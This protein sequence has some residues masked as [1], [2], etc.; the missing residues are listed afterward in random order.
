[1][2]NTSFNTLAEIIDWASKQERCH[3]AQWFYRGHANKK[4]YY[5]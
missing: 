4:H 2:G 5:K 1:M 3:V